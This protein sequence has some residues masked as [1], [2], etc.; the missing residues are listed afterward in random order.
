LADSQ[1]ELKQEYDEFEQAEAS[2]DSGLES[3]PSRKRLPAWIK[4]MVAA[5]LVIA[6]ALV[7]IFVV[8]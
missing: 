3:A 1:E 8:A 2:L 7:L 6:I 5:D 4:W